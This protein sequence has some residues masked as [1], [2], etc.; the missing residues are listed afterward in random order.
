[1]ITDAQLWSIV[2]LAFAILFGTA[3]GIEL[4]SGL[5]LIFSALAGFVLATLAFEII[6]S[7]LVPAVLA[8]LSILLLLRG[9]TDMVSVKVPVDG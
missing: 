9:G 3:L 8:A 2:L 5:F 1:M 6:A 4:E 7:P